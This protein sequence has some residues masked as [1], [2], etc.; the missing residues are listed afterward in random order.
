MN[1]YE[2]R[3]VCVLTLAS[4]LVSTGCAATGS[5]APATGALEPRA[6]DS[7][8]PAAQ[9][10]P[11]TAEREPAEPA[12][13]AEEHPTGSPT[14]QLMKEHFDAAD[15]IR[16]AVI[17]G[18]RYGIFK[19]ARKLIYRTDVLELPPDWRG[20]MAR[21]QDAAWR[22]NESNDMTSAAGAM[23]DV[24][25]SC[26]YCHERLGGPSVSPTSP[27][28]SDG[29]MKDRMQQHAWATERLWEGLYV[30]S[31]DAWNAGIEVLSAEPFPAEVLEHRGVYA[32]SAADDFTEIVA[33]APRPAGAQDRA[34]VYAKLMATCAVCHLPKE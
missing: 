32:R 12:T 11:P 22:L 28:G 10:E 7:S 2:T 29:S 20:P 6:V 8:E 18:S 17:A 31:P 23:A 27:P 33:R 13:S 15:A 24:G 16:Q 30:P 19:P 4:A 9:P 5:S 34:S 1:K 25:T 21:M 26:G 3:A 14:E